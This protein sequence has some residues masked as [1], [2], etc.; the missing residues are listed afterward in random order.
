MLI[1]SSSKNSETSKILKSKFDG[2]ISKLN[3][4]ENKI[5][6][7]SGKLNELNISMSKIIEEVSK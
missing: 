2:I 4:L 6:N 1:M 5:K 3:Q 7:V